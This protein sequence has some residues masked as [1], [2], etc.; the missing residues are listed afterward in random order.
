M[1]L[2]KNKRQLTFLGI[3]ILMLIIVVFYVVFAIYFLAKNA[4]RAF[5]REGLEM[6]A[7]ALRFQIGKAEELLK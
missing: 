3:G 2:L 5:S 7:E 4:N 1:N 6:P